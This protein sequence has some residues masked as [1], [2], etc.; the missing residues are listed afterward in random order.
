MQGDRYSLTQV[1][2]SISQTVHSTKQ[3]SGPLQIWPQLPLSCLSRAARVRRESGMALAVTVV[4][5]AT[6][7]TTRDLGCISGLADLLRRLSMDWDQ[8]EL[9]VR[10]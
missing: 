3:L 1:D 8:E 4:R 10:V 9:I 6:R 5:V 7:A 2:V